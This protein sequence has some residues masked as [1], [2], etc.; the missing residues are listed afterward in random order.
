[1]YAV[2]DFVYFGPRIHISGAMN[3]GIDILSTYKFI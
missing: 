3:S 2:E 1:M